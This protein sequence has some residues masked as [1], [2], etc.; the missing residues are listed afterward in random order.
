MGEMADMALSD[1]MDEEDARTDYRLGFMGVHEAYDRG[2]IDERGYEHHPYRRKAPAS[3]S[4]PMGSSVQVGNKQ[5]SMCKKVGLHWQHT[6]DGW[7][8]FEPTN[9]IHDCGRLP[10]KEL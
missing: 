4:S 8:L 9:V 5:C 7:R 3:W 2:I 1:V 10:R 6:T